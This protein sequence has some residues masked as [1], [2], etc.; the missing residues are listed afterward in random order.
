VTA[1]IQKAQCLNHPRREAAAR[2]TSCGRS[3]CREC[4]T[5]LAGRM[6]CGPCYREKT[7]AKE[8]PK[9]DWFLITATLQIMLGL[10]GLWLMAWMLGQML[11]N[12]PS[13]FHEAT[14][15]DKLSF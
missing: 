10:A 11:V 8:K 12:T 6:V 9:R 7:Q 15:W 3:Y 2:C 14:V 1:T 5:E 4:V 13:E